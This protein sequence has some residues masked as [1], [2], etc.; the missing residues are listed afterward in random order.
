MSHWLHRSIEDE[1][2][3]RRSAQVGRSAKIA[4][5]LDKAALTVRALH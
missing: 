4:S 3:H 2:D 5:R 1:M